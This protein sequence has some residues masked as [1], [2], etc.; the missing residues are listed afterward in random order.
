MELKTFKIDAYF[1]IT[2]MKKSEP[3]LFITT[4]AHKEM[5]FLRKSFEL[6]GVGFNDDKAKDMVKNYLINNVLG[7]GVFTNSQK[8]TFEPIGRRHLRCKYI[9]TV[10]DSKL[11]AKG[12][13][14]PFHKA[15]NP[16]NK[17]SDSL[18]LFL[19]NYITEKRDIF[20]EEP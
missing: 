9:L 2:H 12:S 11:V 15:M 14:Y 6:E 3:Q 1:I 18:R 13:F 7:R 20:D 5:D 4:N 10:S 8:L 17:L 16:K 19:V